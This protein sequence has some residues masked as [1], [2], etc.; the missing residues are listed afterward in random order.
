MCCN[1]LLP[2]TQTTIVFNVEYAGGVQTLKGLGGWRTLSGFNFILIS[3]PG[4]SFLEPW[5]DISERL[6]RIQTE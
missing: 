1:T 6:R 4:F 2:T 3:Y 5:A